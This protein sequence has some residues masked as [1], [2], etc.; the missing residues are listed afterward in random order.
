DAHRASPSKV[1]LPIDP[2]GSTMIVPPM[3]YGECYPASV[4]QKHH[5]LLPIGN[6]SLTIEPGKATRCGTSMMT[7]KSPI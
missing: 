3:G 5:D 1:T 2:P 7:R 4:L 6:K